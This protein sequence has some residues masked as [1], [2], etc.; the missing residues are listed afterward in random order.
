LGSTTAGVRDG[1]AVGRSWGC[2][3]SDTAFLTVLRIVRIERTALKN[4]P[5]YIQYLAMANVLLL[6]KLKTRIHSLISPSKLI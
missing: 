2:V 4:L 6:I 5:V 3:G 1:S